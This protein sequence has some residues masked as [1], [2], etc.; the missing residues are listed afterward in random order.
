VTGPAHEEFVFATSIETIVDYGDAF[1]A[2]GSFTSSIGLISFLTPL[3]VFALVLGFLEGRVRALAWTV[4]ALS[5]V[6]LLGSYGRA[7]LLGL[8][9]GL[10]AALV[11][12]LVAADVE[13]RRKLIA[14]GL[15]VGLVC[16]VYGG[17]VVAS[18]AAPSLER[19][20]H[21]ILHPFQDESLRQRVETWRER[22]D[23]AAAQPLGRGLGTVGAASKPGRGGHVVTADNSYLK[24]LVE[25]GFAGV[26]LFAV[27][28]FG[29]L[30]V[31]ARRMR[32][33]SGESRALG[34]AALGGF[35]AFLG[36]AV[37]GE[38]VEQPGKVVAWTLLGIATAAAFAP[39]PGA[40]GPPAAGGEPD[41]GA[42]DRGA[43]W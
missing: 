15:V 35:V 21:G 16:G 2:I 37:A 8:A 23:D 25:Q 41:R 5:I 14:A 39:A 33:V 22:V 38:Y 26:A 27:G 43:G 19:R 29:V 30:V 7:A 18:R 32:R 34:L 6:G 31:L 13:R 10:M 40:G 1:R 42:P 11:V 36:I 28:L 4:A 9:V 17:L 20:T 3:A 12:V 24:V